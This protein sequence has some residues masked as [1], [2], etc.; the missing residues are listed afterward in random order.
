MR[1]HSL[2]TCSL[3]TLKIRRTPLCL[4]F[5]INLSAIII[6]HVVTRGLGNWNS[7]L[8]AAKY[9]V[10]QWG[11]KFHFFLHFKPFCRIW[12]CMGYMIWWCGWFYDIWNVYYS[13]VA[14]EGQSRIRAQCRGGC[15]IC[16]KKGGGEIQKGGGWLI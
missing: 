1:P 13:S 12:V 11:F 10:F 2:R 14:S 3:Q 6:I 16:K 8:A 15:W 9:C 7:L 4:H 5:H